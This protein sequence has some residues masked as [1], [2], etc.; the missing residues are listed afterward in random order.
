MGI[1][2]SATADLIFDN[3]IVPKENL[4]GKEGDGF[5]MIMQT[6]DIGRIGVGADRSWYC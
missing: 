6:L 4:I 3:C 2:A 5:K 1:R